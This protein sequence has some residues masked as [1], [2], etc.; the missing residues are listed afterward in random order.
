MYFKF[1]S[2]LLYTKHLKLPFK[3]VSTNV[4]ANDIAFC[5][6]GNGAE[7]NPRSLFLNYY[8][9]IFIFNC[10]EG[11]QRLIIDLG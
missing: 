3:N 1:R 10:G 2:I 11:V 5:F 7:G 9:D 6:V 8:E 4:P